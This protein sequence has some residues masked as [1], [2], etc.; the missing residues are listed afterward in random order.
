MTSKDEVGRGEAGGIPTEVKGS[1]SG[2]ERVRPRRTRGFDHIHFSRSRCARRC[3]G[4]GGRAEGGREIFP[5]RLEKKHPE[6]KIRTSRPE[7]FSLA[8]GH[9]LYAR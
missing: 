3:L 1:T 6:E 4:N 5:P 2:T 9:C 7:R 8:S